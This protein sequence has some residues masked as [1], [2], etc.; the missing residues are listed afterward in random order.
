M[1]QISTSTL[2]FYNE[3]AMQT[4]H[5]STWCCHHDEDLFHPDD[6][7]DDS[8]NDPGE[9]NNTEQ[10]L[11][12]HKEF[13]KPN[14]VRNRDDLNDLDFWSVTTQPYHQPRTV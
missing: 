13:Y 8:V 6:Q 7:D 4:T 9:Q 5:F 2:Q 12:V 14:A 3:P 10:R 11:Q 1:F